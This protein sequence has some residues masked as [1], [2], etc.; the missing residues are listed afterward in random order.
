MMLHG[1]HTVIKDSLLIERFKEKGI[2]I[3]VYFLIAVRENMM[4]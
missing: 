4:R 2:D 3:H 1:H